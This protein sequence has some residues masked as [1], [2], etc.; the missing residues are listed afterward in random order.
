LIIHDMYEG[1]PRPGNLG[2]FSGACICFADH[3][4]E[5]LPLATVSSFLLDDSYDIIFRVPNVRS[6]VGLANYCGDSTHALEFSN[7]DISDLSR[8]ASAGSC[9]LGF[10][11]FPWHRFYAP[12]LCISSLPPLIRSPELVIHI[13]RR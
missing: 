12:P 7:L 4:F 10:S 5:H 1:I 8:A 6:P 11:I 3:C 2:F 13:L 9:S